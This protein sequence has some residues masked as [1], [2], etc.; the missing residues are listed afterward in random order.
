[1]PKHEKRNPSVGGDVVK[2]I[3]FENHKS[4]ASNVF[5]CGLGEIK[6]GNCADLIFF[7]YNPP[8]PMNVNN[9]WYH[10]LFGIGNTCVNSTMVDGKFLMKNREMLVCDEKQ[11]LA[12]ANVT[13]KRLWER[14]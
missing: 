1:L 10:L 5:N 11:I 4:I 14:F 8:T 9:I 12:E 7:N 3:I 13:A 2:K 6:I